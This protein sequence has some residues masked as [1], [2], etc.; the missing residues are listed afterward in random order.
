MRARGITVLVLLLWSAIAQANAGLPMLWV[1]WPFAIAAIIP[2]VL[3]EAWVVC[4]GT[5]VTW[6]V[7]LWEMS[8]ANA[9]STLVGLPLTWVALV[10]L[11]YLAAY[12][13]MATKIS[14]G[15]PPSWVGEVGAIVMS[16]PWLG[17]FRTGGHWIV[18]VATATLL[19]PFFFVSAWVEALMVKKAF[20]DLGNTGWRRV[21]WRANLVSY[22][23]LFVATLG[24]LAVGLAKHG[25]STA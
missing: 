9:V 6:R 12:L 14:D 15:Y 17:P 7:G 4:R 1:L 2:V 24:W 5:G 22:A 11:E 10:A 21:I 16:A 23:L 13:T 8:K 18:P 3:L 20:R 25:W 19:A